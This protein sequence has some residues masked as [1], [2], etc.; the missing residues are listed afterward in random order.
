MI[1]R[2]NGKYHVK[3]CH[4]SEDI[5]TDLLSTD[6]SSI[7]VRLQQSMRYPVKYLMVPLKPIFHQ[8]AKLLALGTFASANAKDRT[9]A[10]PNTKNTN[11]LVSLA[12]GEAIFSRFTQRET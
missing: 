8:N 5:T 2:H 12:L 10:L 11:M 7:T 3:C 4:L 1:K 9:F 6:L